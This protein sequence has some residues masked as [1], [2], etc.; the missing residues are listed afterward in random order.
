M[1]LRSGKNP[2]IR[3]E[4]KS[5]QDDHQNLKAS[6]GRKTPSLE[7]P[8]EQEQFNNIYKNLEIPGAFT[9]KIKIYLRQNQTHSLHKSKRMKLT[10]L[11]DK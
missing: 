5:D 10:Y 2:S 8:S 1:R 3:F 11:I 7:K 6:P 9:E 4:K